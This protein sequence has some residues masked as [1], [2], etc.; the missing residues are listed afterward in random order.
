MTLSTFFL[1][2]LPQLLLYPNPTDPLNGQAAALM[3]KQRDVFDNKVREY[4]KLYASQPI[5]VAMD[6]TEDH[7]EGGNEELSEPDDE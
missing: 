6:E 4:V 7:E 5:K 1:L 3:M 2:F